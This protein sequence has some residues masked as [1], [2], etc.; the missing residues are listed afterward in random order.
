MKPEDFKPT[1]RIPAS[2]SILGTDYAV[3][4]RAYQEDPLFEREKYQGYCTATGRLIVVGDLSTFPGEDLESAES[5]ARIRQ[6][7]KE[8]FR[9]EIIHAFL[10]ESGLQGSSNLFGDA[11][12]LNEEMV[13]W[14][15][16]Q[17][18]KIV[19]VMDALLLL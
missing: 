10:N 7:E 17:L 19:A 8:T 3:F 15:A 5:A 13:D 6:A 18:P 9:H 4:F 12:A 2:I 1:F 14:I 11:W 16:I